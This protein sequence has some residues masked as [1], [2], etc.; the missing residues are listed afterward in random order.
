MNCAQILCNIHSHSV[1]EYTNK[2]SNK[3]SGKYNFRP[4]IIYMHTLDIGPDAVVCDDDHDDCD[5]DCHDDNAAHDRD[6]VK[7]KNLNTIT[8]I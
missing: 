5:G 3:L 1:R 4:T 2:N 6:P 8:N 7:I